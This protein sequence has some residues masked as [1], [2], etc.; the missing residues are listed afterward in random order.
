MNDDRDHMQPGRRRFLECMAWAGAG[1]L[2]LMK[3]GI[4]HAGMLAKDAAAA[5]ATFSFVQI[6]DSHI[7]FNKDANPDVVGTLN[8]SIDAVNALP[9]K[10]SFAIHTG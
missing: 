6:S 2:W 9:R 7:G 5:D 4:A 10:P 3:G 8:R 1:T